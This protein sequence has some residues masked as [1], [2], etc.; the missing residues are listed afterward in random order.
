MICATRS[1]GLTLGKFK[2]GTAKL[3]FLGGVANTTADFRLRLL[4]YYYF[5]EVHSNIPSKEA[6]TPNSTFKFNTNVPYFEITHQ[7]QKCDS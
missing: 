6:L 1:D 5:D 7:L 2:N 3:Y 4:G